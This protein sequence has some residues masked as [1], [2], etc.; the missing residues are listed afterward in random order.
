MYATSGINRPVVTLE[1]SAAPE[2]SS[3]ESD[4]IPAHRAIHDPVTLSVIHLIMQF[5]RKSIFFMRVSYGAIL[6]KLS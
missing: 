2:I 4:C 5:F 3:H 6:H 1:I